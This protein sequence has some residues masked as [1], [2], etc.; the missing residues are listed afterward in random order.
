M[1]ICICNNVTESEIEMRYLNGEELG[2][3]G[4]CCR[5]AVE[6]IMIR[7][8]LEK[9]IGYNNIFR[10]MALYS[11]VDVYEAAKM[12]IKQRIIHYSEV[13]SKTDLDEKLREQKREELAY[14]VGLEQ[15]IME[16]ENEIY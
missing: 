10:S 1:I 15:Y 4:R 8:D 3:G 6:E 14:W 7:V 9:E 16:L 12:T 11:N 5:E 2:V 13:I